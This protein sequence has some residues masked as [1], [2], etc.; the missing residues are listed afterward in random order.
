MNI[1]NSVGID[2]LTGSQKLAPLSKFQQAQIMSFMQKFREL[3]FPVTVADVA[4]FSA[5]INQYRELYQD[6]GGNKEETKE[7][8]KKELAPLPVRDY[9]A[10]ISLVAKIERYLKKNYDREEVVRSAALLQSPLNLIVDLLKKQGF[11]QFGIAGSYG[12]RIPRPDSD[13]DLAIY[14]E[15]PLEKRANNFV[16]KQ[17][18]T[19]LRV[20]WPDRID[21]WPIPRQ[22]LISEARLQVVYFSESI[23]LIDL[24][25][26]EE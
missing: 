15:F 1:E 3:G 23:R 9:D 17:I 26:K 13:I 25:P 5:H 10:Y 7:A 16:K 4:S 2:I 6:F 18:K 20:D 8:L 22:F 14:D 21:L 24:V 19:S 11:S 12:A